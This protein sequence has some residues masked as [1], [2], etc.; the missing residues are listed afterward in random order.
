[1]EW[2][3][4]VT[5]LSN[6]PRTSRMKAEF[7]LYFFEFRSKR[8]R[9]LLEPCVAL[10][11]NLVASTRPSQ[12]YGSGCSCPPSPT[13][14]SHDTTGLR[15]VWHLEETIRSSAKMLGGAGCHEHRALSFCCLK[16]CCR[17]S[18]RVTLRAFLF[19]VVHVFCYVNRHATS[20]SSSY[21][22]V[23]CLSLERLVFSIDMI[24]VVHV[25]PCR[26]CSW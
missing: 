8:S 24:A 22:A 9:V 15:T 25:L 1:M 18:E 3:H 11:S 7:N 2:R 23:S 13:S 10:I 6:N 12:A 21:E 19:F 16:C 26:D 5:S 20:C 14:L 17:E 4:F